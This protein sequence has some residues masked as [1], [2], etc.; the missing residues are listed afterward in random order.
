MVMFVEWHKKWNMQ[1]EYMDLRIIIQNNHHLHEQRLLLVCYDDTLN[2]N[3][4]W[5]EKIKNQQPLASIEHCS[6]AQRKLILG[7]CLYCDA[8]NGSKYCFVQKI[9]CFQ[10]HH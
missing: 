10:P 9:D 7:M 6:V 4:I 8:W 5:F 3:T 2:S 1:F